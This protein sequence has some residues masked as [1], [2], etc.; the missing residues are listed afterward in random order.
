MKE[1]KETA[2]LM[3]SVDYKDR[4]AA[5]YYQLETR[6][7]K[8]KDMLDAWDKG[9]LNFKP[10]CPREIYDRQTAAMAQYLDVLAERAELENV[11]LVKS[12]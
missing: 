8:L 4:F 12:I 2:D 7:L 11:E 5:E 10:T 3:S 9:R 6:Y 1:L